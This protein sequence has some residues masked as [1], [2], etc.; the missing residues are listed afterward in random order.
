MQIRRYKHNFNPVAILICQ[1]IFPD[2][3]QD[4]VPFRIVKMMRQAADLPGIQ[5]FL[6]FH[7]IHQ[8]FS[9]TIMMGRD[10]NENN[11]IPV[12]LI[13]MIYFGKCIYEYIQSLVP[14]FIPAAGGYQKC[15][16]HYGLMA[17][18]SGYLHQ[19]IPGLL[20]FHFKLSLFGNE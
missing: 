6:F 17:Y 14:V 5:W 9:G 8:L 1:I 19:Y 12:Y 20:S 7:C 4:G 15:I 18:K 11:N 3:V 2:L 10:Q 13:G 16:L